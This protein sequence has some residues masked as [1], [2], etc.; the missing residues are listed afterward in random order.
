MTAKEHNARC[1]KELYRA[2]YEPN[3]DAAKIALHAAYVSAL[4]VRRALEDET[5]TESPPA[6]ET[7]S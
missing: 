2:M 7:R 4:D 5:P 1:L 6:E 3:A